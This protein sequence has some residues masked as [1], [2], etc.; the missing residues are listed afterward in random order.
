[1]LKLEVPHTP[2]FA[3]YFEREFK[4]GFPRLAGLTVRFYG[5]EDGHV[6]GYDWTVQHFLSRF[7]EFSP[8]LQS[9]S[10]SLPKDNI[11][12]C[13]GIGNLDFFETSLRNITYL[14][15]RTDTDS[16]RFVLKSCQRLVSVDIRLHAN[17][18]WVPADAYPLV[19]AC[20]RRLYIFCA[21]PEHAPTLLEEPM[22]NTTCPHLQTFS[23]STQ[24]DEEEVKLTSLTAAIKRFSL[25]SEAASG[26]E[27]LSIHRL[28]LP[29]LD[30]IVELVPNLRKLD[31]TKPHA[32]HNKILKGF[33]GSTA[34]SFGNALKHLE[35]IHHRTT[36][37]EQ[38]DP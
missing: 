20:L 9:L 22:E 7:S 21:E 23:L 13:D 25:R 33:G 27:A 34:F 6:G 4:D 19:A 17:K 15:I 11:Q 5:P 31:I 3:H 14:R 12:D 1:M 8:Q 28:Y 10:L 24:N 32:K 36:V 26:M 37:L 29:N 30:R 2:L 18:E 35:Y 16:A 38:A